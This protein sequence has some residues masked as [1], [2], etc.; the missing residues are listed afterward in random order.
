MTLMSKPLALFAIAVP[1]RPMP[2]IPSVFPWTS[3]PMNILGPQA[4]TQP[5]ALTWRSASAILLAA[6]ISRA[7]AQSAVVSVSIPGVL[8]T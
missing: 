8:V 4:W 2:M 3:E 6:A 7:K 1:I 5:P